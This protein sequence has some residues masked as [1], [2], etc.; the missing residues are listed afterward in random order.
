MVLLPD[1]GLGRPG[2][3]AALALDLTGFPSELG[4]CTEAPKCP[5]HHVL[6]GFTTSHVVRAP[7]PFHRREYQGSGV[8]GLSGLMTRPTAPKGHSPLPPVASATSAPDTLG[9]KTKTS[10][11]GWLLISRH[12]ALLVLVLA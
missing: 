3:L 1:E 11:R 7:S 12:R 6:W 4:M 9:D 10:P 8:W 5:R 2:G